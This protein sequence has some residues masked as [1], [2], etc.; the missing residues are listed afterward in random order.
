[1]AEDIEEL[2]ELWSG[3]ESGWTLHRSYSARHKLFILL[4]PTPVTVAQLRALR[5]LSGQLQ[6]VPLRDLK[7][8]IPA[9]GRVLIGEFHGRLVRD[10]AEKAKHLGLR[11]E[12]ESLVRDVYLP[13]NRKTGLTWLIE[14]AET[15][16]R[17]AERMMAAGMPVIDTEE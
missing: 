16:Q 9:D 1:M 11:F 13:V 15:A 6:E 5:M 4:G 8:R 14:D 3:P 7:S 17:V 10:V 2:R 12:V